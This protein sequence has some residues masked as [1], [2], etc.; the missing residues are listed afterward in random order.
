MNA[1]IRHVGEYA[2]V[3]L[4]HITRKDI[5]AALLDVRPS[6]MFELSVRTPHVKW[7]DIAGCEEVRRELEEA[8]K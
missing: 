5:E 8:V 1:R 3:D 6:Q 7:E 2:R 4:I